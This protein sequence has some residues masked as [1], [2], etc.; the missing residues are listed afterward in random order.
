MLKT[1]IADLTSFFKELGLRQSDKVMIHSSLFSL[2]IIER[3]IEGFH[4]AVMDVI[5]EEGCIIVP[6]FTHSYRHKKIYDI[7]LTSSDKTL[8][9][10]PEF[11]RKK[12]GASRN[13]DPLF[14]MA[15]LG[16]NTEL[17]R[18]RTINCFGEGSVYEKLF[19]NNI[20]FLAL[21][22]TYS[23]GLSAFMHLEKLAGVPYR[24]DLLLCGESI[25]EGG[26]LHN[27]CAMHFARDEDDFYIKGR[28]NR[29]PMGGLLEGA[30]I[31][32]ALTFRNGRHFALR[33]GLFKE[34]VLEK[35]SCDTMFMFD[36]N[37]N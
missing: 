5:G 3:G 21:G 34:F 17:I 2:G 15:A 29:E 13:M 1:S 24:K 11:I 6:T 7:K 10:Y 25:D 8:G 37:K 12:E 16:H 27:D 18:R 33:A 14:S 32:K 28:T 36:T 26:V 20:V 31:S 19:D 4:Q 9:M 35:L 30:G 23:T 22:I